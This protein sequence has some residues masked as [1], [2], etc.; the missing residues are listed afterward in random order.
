MLP[1][2]TL[3]H[4]ALALGLD[5]GWEQEGPAGTDSGVLEGGE[6]NR[7]GRW[8]KGDPWCGVARSLATL[9]PVVA[10][11][12]GQLP[13]GLDGPAEEMSCECLDEFCSSLPKPGNN[14]DARQLVSG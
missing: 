11:E 6:K 8:K 13:Y 10:Q 3:S 2:Q 4:T 12:V 7:T 5:S 14:S 1:I 9:P